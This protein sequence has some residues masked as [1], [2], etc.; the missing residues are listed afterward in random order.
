MSLPDETAKEQTPSQPTA[1]PAEARPLTFD[2]WI[3]NGVDHFNALQRADAER[4]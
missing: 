3:Q 4:D 2:Q 1:T